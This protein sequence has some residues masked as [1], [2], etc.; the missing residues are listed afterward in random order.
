MTAPGR[1]LTRARSEWIEGDPLAIAGVPTRRFSRQV[2]D[3][4]LLALLSHD[5]PGW[6]LSVSF[7]DHRGG[8]G[9]YPSWD[10][11]ADARYRL[12]D[13][14]IDMVMHLPP[15]AEYVAVHDTTFH[16]HELR[17]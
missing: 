3:G 11:I 2:R 9:R 8:H 6:H 10:E 16:L 4:R 15:P 12:V 17:A 5:P 14:D 13:P 1:P 7:T